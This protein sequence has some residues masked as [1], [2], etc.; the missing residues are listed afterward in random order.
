MELWYTPLSFPRI[1][2]V[3]VLPLPFGLSSVLSEP[4]QDIKN[5]EKSNFTNKNRAEGNPALWMASF[6]AQTKG[7]APSHSN[8]TSHLSSS[9]FVDSFALW[10][11]SLAY[12]GSE[13]STKGEK[14]HRNRL[15]TGPTMSEDT[16]GMFT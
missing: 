11:L 7:L 12:H 1:S 6:E 5:Q 14:H 13:T 9:W 3:P 2:F 10:L 8:Q 16:K 15:E 4:N